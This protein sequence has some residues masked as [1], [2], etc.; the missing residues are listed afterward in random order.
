MMPPR[1]EIIP[2]KSYSSVQV[3][4]GQ[5]LGHKAGCISYRSHLISQSL[6]LAS[7]GEASTPRFRSLATIHT[8]RELACVRRLGFMQRLALTVV[9]S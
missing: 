1:T 6:E 3:V 5:P 9:A 7:A 2:S 4:H 8:L